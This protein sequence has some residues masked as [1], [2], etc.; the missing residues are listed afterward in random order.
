MLISVTHVRILNSVESPGV[1]DVMLVLGVSLIL[2][3]LI[4]P[5]QIRKFKENKILVKD[6]YKN[7]VRE[8]PTAGGFSILFVLLLV[9]VLA[10]IF[11]EDLGVELSAL[12]TVAIVVIGLYGALGAIDDF[13]D[14]NRVTKIILPFFLALPLGLVVPQY[15]IPIPLVGE[16]NPGVLYPFI[17]A[18]A[19]VMVVSNLVNMHSGF[20]GMSV[21]LSA[22]LLFT[23]LIKSIMHGRDTILTT[24]AVLGA[25]LG[26]LYYNW[27]PSQIFEGN[28]G[29]LAI[30][31]AIGVA[32]VANGF[33]VSG[34][35]ILIP[36]TV[37]FLMYVCWRV[38]RR[39][40]PEDKRWELVKFGRV[41]KDGTLEIPNPFTLKWV[42]PHYFRMTEKQVVLSMYGLTGVFCAAGLF[43]PY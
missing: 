6:Y 40:H 30:G 41:R 36:H 5:L 24:S 27:Y 18:P 13:V 9:F 39:L 32:I 15:T 37:N 7:D 43:I 42:L 4:V 34:F 1:C 8:V 33:L 16:V 3:A 23:L 25:L 11:G 10:A 26:F 22:M 31:A 12:D 20:N 19:Y 17:I 29:S 21:G 35:I 2:S 14:V 38:M 28:V